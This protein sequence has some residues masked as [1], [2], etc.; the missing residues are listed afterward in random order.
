M[1]SDPA[2]E[3]KRKGSKILA[4]GKTPEDMLD[5]IEGGVVYSLGTQM[6][7]DEREIRMLIDTDKDFQYEYFLTIDHTINVY[8][9]ERNYHPSCFGWGFGPYGGINGPIH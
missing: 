3:P 6:G 5:I 2:G 7:L 4:K 1:S 8:I 9:N